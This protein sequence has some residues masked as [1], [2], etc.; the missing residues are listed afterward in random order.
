MDDGGVQWW[1]QC[2]QI[3]CEWWQEQG[4][5]QEREEYEGEDDEQLG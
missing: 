3:E 5:Q 1:A 2:G 4:R